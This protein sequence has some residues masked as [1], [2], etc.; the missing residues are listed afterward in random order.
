LQN[1]VD[2]AKKGD[3]IN[4][5][6][7]YA[8]ANGDSKEGVLINKSISINGNGMVLD[9]KDTSRIFK[10]IEAYDENDNDD[11]GNGVLIKNLAFINGKSENGGAIYIGHDL[12]IIPDKSYTD[13]TTVKNCNFMNCFSKMGGSIYWNCTLG[14]VL[15]SSFTNSSAE[16]GGAIYANEN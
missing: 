6:K 5:N 15:N 4:L 14:K 11:T 10:I 8:Y 13:N 2:N 9:G 12:I 1:I 7:N 16:T 3:T